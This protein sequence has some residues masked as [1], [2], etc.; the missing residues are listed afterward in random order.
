M[1]T[2][3]RTI[4][5]AVMIG[6]FLLLAPVAVFY[7]L[8]Y[9]YD[10]NRGQVLR[11]GAVLVTT[12]PR[13][14]TVTLDSEPARKRTPVVVRNVLPGEHLLRVELEGYET[15][16]KRVTILAERT[17]L[18]DAILLAPKHD[19]WRVERRGTGAPPVV[20]PD[21]TAI[22]WN[23]T[24]DTITVGRTTDAN[25]DLI[26]DHSAETISGWSPYSRYLLTTGERSL[27]IYDRNG[28]WSARNMGVDQPIR[29]VRWDQANESYAYLLTTE[30]T[31]VVDAFAGTVTR[32]PFYAL[33]LLAANGQLRTIERTGLSERQRTLVFRSAPM[34]DRST[35][36]DLPLGTEAFIAA[37][38]NPVVTASDQT[39]TTVHNGATQTRAF[40]DAPRGSEWSPQQ[41]A[42]L[43]WTD[44][45]LWSLSLDGLGEQLIARTGDTLHTARWVA[46]WPALV[47]SHGT[48]IGFFDVDPR[49]TRYAAPLLTRADVLPRLSFRGNQLL[50]ASADEHGWT[51]ESLQLF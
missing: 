32:L 39:I 21:G 50:S 8:G 30:A 35:S 4:F 15:F 1:Q 48:E 22:A 49:G 6:L 47:V 27:T 14:A 40:A 26:L 20:S 17:T 7:A 37:S 9:R 29:Y 28:D 3:V 46:G 31:F 25:A 13:N 42:L 18:Y 19:R 11:T 36:L 33:D 12:Y 44:D 16:E 5:L 24:D 2:R 34:Y 41:A 51:I 23:A 45:E 43:V 38:L 10:V